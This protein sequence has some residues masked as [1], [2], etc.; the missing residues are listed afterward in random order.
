MRLEETLRDARSGGRPLLVPY[1]TGGLHDGWTELLEA[2]VAA[3]ADAVEIGI[4]FSDPVMDG[5]TIQTA[6]QQALAR[7][8]TPMTILGDV[9]GLAVGAPLAVMTYANLVMHAGYDRFASALVDAGVDAAILPDLPLDE[10][11]PWGSAADAAGIET[12]LLA[13]PT[14]TD[15]RLAR[16]CERSKGFVYA[17]SLLG[18]TGERGSL[19]EPSSTVGERCRGLTDTPV[20]LGVGISTPEQA[21]EAV[22]HA[23]GVVIGSALIRRLLDG[24]GVDVAADFI[25]EVRRALDETAS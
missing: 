20:L 11:G 17:V 12:V 24:G 23:D 5:P 13:A 16:I 19:S 2:V 25:R 1:V 21:A 7:G 10:F 14:T 9:E 6:S 18:V 15:E 8:A 3:G 22:R 4:P